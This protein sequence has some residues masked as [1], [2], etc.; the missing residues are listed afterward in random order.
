[1]LNLV[2]LNG[3]YFS[4]RSLWQGLSLVPRLLGPV[5]PLV[6]LLLPPLLLLFLLL[7]LALDEAGVVGPVVLVVLRLRGERVRPTLFADAEQAK[8]LIGVLKEQVRLQ[9]AKVGR[10]K[11]AYGA[12]GGGVIR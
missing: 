6:P 8:V 7:L 10:L 5:P 9:F 3:A 11:V 12:G 4:G 2:S 1:M